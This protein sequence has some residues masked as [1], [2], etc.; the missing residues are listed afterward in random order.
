MWIDDEN[1]LG[2]Q[3]GSAISK[4]NYPA[5]ETQLQAFDAAHLNPVVMDPLYGAMIK[6]QRTTL[7][8]SGDYTYISNSSLADYILNLI[9]TQVIPFQIGKPN[10]QQH[11]D[12]VAGQAEV[13]MSVVDPYVTEWVVKCDA[14]NNTAA[15]FSAKKFVLTIGVKFTPTSEMIDFIFING[16]QGLSITEV[17]NKNV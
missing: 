7:Q 4:F 3:L 10:D 1:G 17:I 8:G 5:T 9:E 6:S 15:I 11:R 13:V 2:G 16:P 14:D 12:R